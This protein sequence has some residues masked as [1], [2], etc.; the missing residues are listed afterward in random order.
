VRLTGPERLKLS[1]EQ[2][3]HLIE[4]LALQSDR[5][6]RLKQQYRGTLGRAST[7][8]TKVDRPIR[9]RAWVEDTVEAVCHMIEEV[10]SWHLSDVSE[11][12]LISRLRDVVQFLD[13]GSAEGAIKST[14]RLTGLVRGHTLGLSKERQRYLSTWAECIAMSV[15][16][17]SRSI[18]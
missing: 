13:G 14:D 7:G 2:R 10:K 3:N 6:L 17:R 16:D 9:S 4:L 5:W 12:V 15:L 1:N 11:G 8:A 18:N